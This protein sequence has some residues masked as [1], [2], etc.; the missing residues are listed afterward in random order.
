MPDVRPSNI[1]REEA[2]EYHRVR[3]RG[4]GAPVRLSPRWVEGTFWVVILLFASAVVFAV[5]ARVHQYANGLAVVQVS[6]RTTVTARAAGVVASFDVRPGERVHAGQVMVRLYGGPEAT[7]L[8]R[9]TSE[10]EAQLV[11]VLRDPADSAARQTLAALRAERERRAAQLNERSI[12][13]PV[14]GVVSDVRARLGQSLAPGDVVA[15]L[16]PETARFAVVAL[17]PGS[18]RPLLRPG[19]P[20]RIE[21]GGYPFAYQHLSIERVGD[22]IIGPGEARR[23]LGPD[24]AD[25]LAIDGPL[26]L[27][28]ASIPSRTFRAEG[29]AYPYYDGMIGH[30]EARVRTRSLFAT[31]MPWLEYLRSDASP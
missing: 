5:V 26:V 29:R 27:V 3:P 1:F 10:F 11:K 20:L 6:E 24:V 19:V 22:D 7:D 15:S 18:A 17:L 14:G 28:W 13:A 31:L 23:Y 21:M 4:D 9:F 16:V 30:A 25:A 12:Q 8:A 2:L